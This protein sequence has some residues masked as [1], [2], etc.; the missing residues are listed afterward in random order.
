MKAAAFTTARLAMRAQRIDDA[1]ALHEAY[2]DAELMRYWSSAPHA[3]IEESAAYL[4]PP[5]DHD[6]WRGWSITLLGDDRAIGTLGASTRR[7][8]VAEIGYLLVRSAWGRGYAR[9]AVTGLIDLLFAEGN[10][11]VF[12]DADPDNVASIGLLESLGFQ[13]EGLL[14]AEWE[15]HIGVRDSVI[16]GLLKDEWRTRLRQKIAI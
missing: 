14:R 16:L 6:Q 12:A 1:T 7:V 13:R 15:T 11:R 5:V 4:T 8:G 9:E 3:T 10:R 2:R